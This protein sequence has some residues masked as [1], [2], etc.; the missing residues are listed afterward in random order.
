M[1]KFSID[2]DL[3]FEVEAD[4]EAEARNLAKESVKDYTV[5]DKQG[6]IEKILVH[7]TKSED[8]DILK[9]YIRERYP[10]LKDEVL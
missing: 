10:R 4:K 5:K 9:G 6:K 3:T 1:S 8:I 2:L 7:K